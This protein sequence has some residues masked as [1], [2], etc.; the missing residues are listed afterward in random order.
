MNIVF[1]YIV[2]LIILLEIYI[3]SYLSLFCENYH[4]SMLQF[5]FDELAVECFVFHLA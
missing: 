5:G 3:I 1:I 2:I 4:S